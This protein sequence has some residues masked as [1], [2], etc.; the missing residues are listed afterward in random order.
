[1]VMFMF[2]NVAARK[3]SA[4]IKAIVV[5]SLCAVVLVFS[6]E[7]GSGAVEGIRLCL[8]VLIPSLFP[9][10]VI[11]SFIVKSGLS[12]QIGKPLRGITKHLFGLNECFAPIIILSILG[13]YP[14]GA[15]GISEIYI[16]GEAD[17]RECKKAS[18]FC[19]CSGPGFLVNYIGSSIYNNKKVGLILLFSQIISV[20]ILGILNNIFDKR[21]NNYISDKELCIKNE[22]IGNSLVKAVA[23]GSKG[24]LAICS[25]V[26]IYSA[27]AGILNAVLA[28]GL[29]KNSLLCLFEVC[30][31]VNVMSK[32]CPIE[33]VA[34]AS[35]FGGLCVHFQ[36]Y[37]ALGELKI[38]KLLFYVY[39][40]MQGIITALL[41]HAGLMILNIAKP[42]FST[43]TIEEAGTYGA[44]PM[45]GIVIV[46]LM[47]CF[48]FS[49]KSLRK[50]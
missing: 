40:I 28:D 22:P 39:R 21:R 1:M 11:S 3:L 32:S 24:M 9:F 2:A 45:S 4:V 36:I 18:L 6:K 14:I 15:K 46:V 10:M 29:F 13:G 47:I 26:V 34:F 33:A 50:N 5:F 7:C 25:F 19:V 27:F 30:S 48:L 44:T 8:T 23:D 41:T 12:Y 49:I 37:S 20:L 43:A 16:R 38:S 17:E 31:A 42:V 35:G